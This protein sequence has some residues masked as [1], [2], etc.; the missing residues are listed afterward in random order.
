M[1]RG[2]S[3]GQTY[4]IEWVD[5]EE[6][7]PEA[8]ETNPAAVFMQGLEDGGA[9]FD[10]LEGCWYG[11]GSVFFH[12]TSGGEAGNG[13][14]WQY[15]PSQNKLILVFESPSPDVL[16]NP[17]N[18]TVSPWGGIV[19]CEDGG[20]TDYVRG[21]TAD[22]QVFDIAKNTLNNS[23]WAGATFS[24][25]GKTL[26]VNIQGATRGTAA[27]HAGEGMTLAIWGPWQ[28]GAV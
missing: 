11:D 12:D 13:Q 25:D 2:Q 18:L 19:M 23:E 6:P 15:I 3:V 17:D 16:D 28:R 5:I 24:P 27:A 7:D 4:D 21:L 14:V 26:F 8:A 1:F 22:G 9:I 10:R 20:G